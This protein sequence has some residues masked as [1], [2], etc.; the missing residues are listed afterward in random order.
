MRLSHRL[1]LQSLIVVAVLVVSVVLIIDN[2]IHDNITQQATHDLAGEARLVATQWTPGVDADRLADAAGAATGHRVTLIDS[3]GSVIGDSEFDG[4]ALTSLQNH[5]SRPEVIAARK[6]GV[7]S[8]RRMS[9]STGEEQLYVAVSAPSGVARVSVQTRVVEEIFGTARRGVMLAGL[10]SFLLAAVLA[11]L[12]SR[13]VSRPIT[14]LSEVAAALAAGDL[15]RRPGLV[16]PG[17]VGDL[18]RALHRLAEQLESRLTALA[19]EQSILTSLVES[20]NE[21]VLAISSDRT[22]IRINDTARQ[23]L[24]LEQRVPFSTDYLPRDATLHDAI[25]SALHGVETEQVEVEIGNSALSLTARPLITGGAVI[26][27]FDLTLIRRLEAVRRDF[28]ANV[29]HELRTPLTIV[30]G[31]AETLK[32]PSVPEAKRV[33]FAATIFA[34]AQRMQRIVDELLD[35]SRIESGHWQPRPEKIAIADVSKDIIGRVEQTAAT[36]NVTVEA[37]TD[38][39]SHVYADRTALEQILAN[40]VENSLRYAPA[41]GRIT[42]ESLPRNGG[43]EISVS[44]NG[45]GIPPEHLQRI[46]E[47][48]YRAD[49]GRSREAGGTG[50]G[51]AIVKHLAEAHNGSVSAESEP[52]VR[53]AV[54]VFF[55]RSSDALS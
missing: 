9:P 13:A 49:T 48:F 6:T 33:E 31:F 51:L 1:L 11:A 20:F 25:Q 21:G 16:A 17:E 41:G 46:F 7:G 55:P 30:G 35:L 42:I 26:A 38:G 52:G 45:S 3:T 54:R 44:D 39:A 32:D 29:S 8:V 18:A 47:R 22:V 53:T 43:V 5:N 10:V 37:R 15:K 2:E 12:F 14:E 23:M 27:L 19:A 4:P 36:K 34:N 40:L 24:S 50:L 28:V